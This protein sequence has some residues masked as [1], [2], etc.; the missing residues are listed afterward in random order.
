[1]L[2]LNWFLTHI[3][4]QG[5]ERPYAPKPVDFDDSREG[6]F[7]PREAPDATFAQIQSASARELS[8]LERSYR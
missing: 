7:G 4:A 3:P 1:M 2:Q 8:R 5:S 6:D